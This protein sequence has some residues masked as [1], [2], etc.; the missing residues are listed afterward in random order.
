MIILKEY[1][2]LLCIVYNGAEIIGKYFHKIT[3]P[4]QCILV[5]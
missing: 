1:C 3:Q 2:S 5:A 4:L